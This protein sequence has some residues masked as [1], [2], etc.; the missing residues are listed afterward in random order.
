MSE[1]AGIWLCLFEPPLM[2]SRDAVWN[3][4]SASSAYRWVPQYLQRLRHNYSLTPS[5]IGPFNTPS[6]R[7]FPAQIALQMGASLCRSSVKCFARDLVWLHQLQRRLHCGRT[8]WVSS[9]P[10]LGKMG[11]VGSCYVHPSVMTVVVRLSRPW[12]WTMRRLNK[13]ATRFAAKCVLAHIAARSWM[14]WHRR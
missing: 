9:S 6:S 10:L 13:K 5:M 4:M 2:A 1:L 12:F 8:L 7:T 11:D 3:A 14:R